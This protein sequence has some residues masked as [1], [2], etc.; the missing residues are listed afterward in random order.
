MERNE[1]N[2]TVKDL[3]TALKFARISKTMFENIARD[4]LEDNNNSNVGV[5]LNNIASI[6]N[7][8]CNSISNAIEDFKSE[9]HM[10]GCQLSL[11]DLL[12][13]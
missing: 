2:K 1:Y 13:K 9:Q 4:I 3:K 8:N 11:F 7:S 6:L 12:D 5:L 10:P